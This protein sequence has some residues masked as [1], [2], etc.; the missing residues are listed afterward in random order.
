MEQAHA[1]M[2]QR[3]HELQLAR[4]AVAGADADIAIAG[5]APNPILSLGSAR[6]GPGAGP[7]ADPLRKRAETSVGVSQLFERGNKREIR[8]QA[9][10]QNAAAARGDQLDVERQ[11]RVALGRAYY[12]LVLA[13]EK[14]R[15]ATDTS[16]LF[17]KTLQA[18]ERRVQAGDLSRADL[19]RLNVDALRARNEVQSVQL[20]QQKAQVA[21]AYLVGLERAARSIRAAQGW[22]AIR[23]L[24]AASEIERVVERR[25]DVRAAQARLL[26]ADRNR[27]L[28]L[29]L[30]TRD[31]TAGVQFDHTPADVTRNSVGFSVSVPLFTRYYF[32]G[33]IRRASADYLAAQAGLERTRAAAISEISGATATLENAA[34]RVRRFQNALLA[35]ADQ[36]AN[37][38]ELAYTRG[39]IG[40]MDLLDSRRQLYA[41]RLESVAALADYA[42]A[43]AE[44]L[45][46][47][48][49]ASEGNP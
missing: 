29:A 12:D 31:V 19:A 10:Q 2:L 1:L 37:G 43:Y 48:E 23:P 15:I 33:E 45:A 27:D 3:N 32:Q 36:A 4:H 14:Y 18:A 9:A 40:V 49:S 22:P 41:T 21:L 11:Q 6:L 34:E 39:A 26:A 24:A 7:N 42:R 46:A 25:A 8:V 44:W 38:A 30:R 16:G 17:D 35:A 5:A 47:S 20:E 13:Q 28:A